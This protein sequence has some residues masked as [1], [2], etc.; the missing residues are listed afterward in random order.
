MGAGFC[1]ATAPMLVLAMWRRSP[2]L[3]VSVDGLE[4]E[5]RPLCQS[6]SSE[7][8]GC[9]PMLWRQG[10]TCVLAPLFM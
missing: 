5:G 4:Y 8:V 10:H 9:S 2:C 1:Q 7:G 6:G 3:A